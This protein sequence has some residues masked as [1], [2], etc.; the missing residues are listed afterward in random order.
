M[1]EYYM[2][3]AQRQALE[4]GTIPPDTLAEAQR[5]EITRKSLYPK[6][7]YPLENIF[8]DLVCTAA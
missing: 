1:R 7:L 2:L 5:P 8:I 3:Q 6:I 4:D